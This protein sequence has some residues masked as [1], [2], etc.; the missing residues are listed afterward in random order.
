MNTQTQNVLDAALAL[1]EA[2][3]MLLVERLLE[4]LPPEQ[5]DL[6]EDE[7]FE[8]LERRRAEVESGKAKTIPWSEL[9]RDL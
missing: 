6:T 7:L 5:D 4:T 1:S 9:R 8:E 2:D 3:R